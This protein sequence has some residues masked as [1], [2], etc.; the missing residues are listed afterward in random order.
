MWVECRQV[1]AWLVGRA[2]GRVGGWI[3]LERQV[4]RLRDGELENIWKPPQGRPFL[5]SEGL[6]TKKRAPVIA[7]RFTFLYSSCELTCAMH[8]GLNDFAK[9]IS[10]Y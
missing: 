9:A 3:E 10:N 4:E 1:N 5:V 6:I 2:G 8:I 7:T